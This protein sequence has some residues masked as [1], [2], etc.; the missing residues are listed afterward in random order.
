MNGTNTGA[1]YA[2]LLNNIPQTAGQLNVVTPSTATSVTFPGEATGDRA[3]FS[4]ANAGNVNNATG[5]INDI[6]IGAP[7]RRALRAGPISF[8]AGPP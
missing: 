4:V 5:G 7:V 6:L 8:T 2:I 3:G 1:V